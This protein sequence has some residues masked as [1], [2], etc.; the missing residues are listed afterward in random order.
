MIHSKKH[1]IL[2]GFKH[3]GKSTVGKQ[4][5]R[6]LHSTF[7]DLDAQIKK[8]YEQ[9][10]GEMLS[11]REIFQQQGEKFFRALET[12]EL[13]HTLQQKPPAII[14]LG[15]G[16][17]LTAANQPYLKSQLVIY[18]TAQPQIVYQRMMARGR[19]A[20]FPPDQDPQQ[21]FE[22]L[23]NERKSVYAKLADI[24]I[25]NTSAVSQTVRLIIK[26]L[27]KIGEFH[28]C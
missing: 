7:I 28:D 20:F 15:G 10:H 19:P 14:A 23:W 2:L 13:I 3:V 6:R 1:I 25:D 8:N 22:H 5:A 27:E 17:P 24:T 11:C 16:T 4:L 9:H 12:Q 21:Y 18:L 26:E